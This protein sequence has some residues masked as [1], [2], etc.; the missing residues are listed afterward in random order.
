[1]TDKISD[2]KKN[3]QEL[4][5]LLSLWLHLYSEKIQG[6][7]NVIINTIISF[8]HHLYTLNCVI[9]RLVESFGEQQLISPESLRTP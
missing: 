8:S 2:F 1:M 5:L 4:S 9:P 6:I 3:P 7:Q